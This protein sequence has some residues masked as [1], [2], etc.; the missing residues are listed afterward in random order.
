MRL[1]AA[2]FAIV[3]ACG[4]APAWAEP[5]PLAVK[6]RPT[7][8]APELARPRLWLRPVE[9][10]GE[11]RSALGEALFR[12]PELLGAVARRSGLSCQAC[13]IN[14]G[15]N[16]KFYI[17]GISAGAGGLDLS[18]AVFN[19]LADDGVANHRDIPS[20]AGIADTA[21]YGRDGTVRTLRDFTRQVIVHE[22]AGAEPPALA[23]DALGAYLIRFGFLPNPR[24][25]ASG[26]L[27]NLAKGS[28]RRGQTLFTRPFP[29]QLKLSCATCHAPDRAFIDQRQHDVGTTGL[30]DTPTLLGIASTAPYFHDGRAQSLKAVVEHFDRH[31]K[32]S[33][34]PEEQSDLID[35]LLAVG[36]TNR[37]EDPVKRG[38]E[39]ARVDRFGRAL[40]LVIAERNVELSEIVVGVLRRELGALN[41]RFPLPQQKPAR[42]YLRAISRGLQSLGEASERRAWEDAE[43]ILEA[44]RQAL[45]S[46]GDVLNLNAVGA[47]FA[48]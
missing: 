21:P 29:G 23:L 14:G 47:L 12:A 46:L 37:G 44:T 18:S 38:D 33:L 28:A 30:F 26:Q 10:T 7:S 22:F 11:A 25:D 17:A 4:G 2:F 42:D 36:G 43:E 32:L 35:Y 19:P 34:S 9:P 40:D 45:S 20:L 39:L 6:W 15:N 13:H 16:A 3:V 31:Y 41:E 48:P 8:A 24:L 27:T 1:S 5:P